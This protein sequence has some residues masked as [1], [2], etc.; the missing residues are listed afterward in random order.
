MDTPWGLERWTLSNMVNK[1]D[2]LF[3]KDIRLT[4]KV[5]LRIPTVEDIAYEENYSSYSQPFNVST[6]LMFSS[7]KEVDE[8][9]T[10]FPTIWEM[11]FHPEGDVILGQ[12]FGAETGTDLIISGLSFWTRLDKSGFKK[13][14]NRK[15]VNEEADWIIDRLA[16]IEFC[17]TIKTLTTY[18]EDQ[19]LIA[20]RNM[21][22]RQLGIWEKTYKGR[23]RKRQKDSRTLADKI[24]ILQISM[25]AYIPIDEIRKMS[26]FHFNKLYEGVSE[27]E[28]YEKQW[29]V[30]MS[31]KFDSGNNTIQHW[32]ERFKV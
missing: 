6:R 2:I 22:E 27:K 23:M 26:I 25:D 29:Q 14:S 8:L 9:E 1:V 28:S 17:E 4:D 19:D 18:E 15:I 32:K 3:G 20:P 10:Q 16:F 31:P 5:S 7:L 21:S 12:M 11:I 24:V 30:K 13:L